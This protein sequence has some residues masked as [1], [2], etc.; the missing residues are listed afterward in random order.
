MEHITVKKNRLMTM[1]LTILFSTV[2][3][4]CAL[5]AGL[6]FRATAEED[7]GAAAAYK[8]ELTDVSVSFNDGW[9]FTNNTPD[10]ELYKMVSVAVTYKDV[11]SNEVLPARV[12]EISVSGTAATGESVSFTRDTTTRK[13]TATVTP[14]GEDYDPSPMSGTSAAYTLSNVSQ[15]VINGITATYESDGTE[16]TTTT[17]LS[18]AA[19]KRNITVYE[20]Y[21]DGSIN[22][23]GKVSSF[24]L[25]G[26][27]FPAAFTDGMTDGSTYDKEITVV[28][29]SGSA[30]V[31]ITGI[32]FVTPGQILGI[33]G[34]LQTQV[35]RSKRLNMD[36]L[37]IVVVY[38]SPTFNMITV[39]ASSF[40]SDH[41]EYKY[42]DASDNEV[43]DASGNPM[44]STA[45]KNV[46]LTFNYPGMSPV[47]AIFA[48]IEVSR[49]SI[50]TPIFPDG[51]NA[52]K[53]TLSWNNGA[54]I[55]ITSWDFDA[56][57]TDTGDAPNPV[58]TV[59]KVDV[60][61]GETPVSA[62]DAPVDDSVDGQR[63]VEFPSAGYLY[64]VKVTLPASGDFMWGSPFNGNKSDD[65]LT[66][67]FDAQVDKG[68]PEVVL[69][70]IA[71]TVYG[72]PN[73]SGTLT[74]TIE[75][76]DMGKTWSEV[77][78]PDYN[79][80]I[81][82]DGA[83]N[84]RLEYYT[85]S[86][87]TTP[88]PAADLRTDGRPKKGG[89]YYAVAVTYENSG[90]ESATSDPLEFAVK[91][92]EVN[93]TVADKTF[94]RTDWTIDDLLS[95]GNTFPYGETA[96]SI[97]TIKEG[98]VA[99]DSTKKF[100]NAGNYTVT[101]SVNQTANYKLSGASS[102]SFAIKTN[103][104]STFDFSVNG[105]TYGTSGANPGI[106][107]TA[108]SNPYYP[109]NTGTLDTDYTVKYYKYDNTQPN[110]KGAEITISSAS[111]F[112][113]LEVGGYVVE[114]TAV[115]DAAYSTETAALTA[116]TTVDYTLPVVCKEFW[117]TASPI[118]APQLSAPWDLT[119][120]NGGLLYT[121]DDTQSGQ[122]YTFT[123]W[124]GDA[125]NTAAD[126]TAILTVAIS[127]T[128]FVSGTANTVT[129]GT[130]GTFTVDY[131]GNYE[132]T[133][134]LNGN[135][136]WSDKDTV[137]NDVWKPTDKSY[138]YYGYV[139]RQQLAILSNSKIS[140]AKNVYDSTVQEKTIGDWNTN[141]LKITSVTVAGVE[142][143]HTPVSG[144]ITTPSD[145][146]NKFSVKNAGKYTVKVDI[147]DQDNYEWAGATTDAE[148]LRTLLLEYTLNRAPMKVTWGTSNL[149]GTFDKTD[150]TAYPRFEFDGSKSEQST[151]VATV[152]VYSGDVVTVGGY[153][154]YNDTDA[155]GS[156][157]TD[158]TAIGFYRIV[159]S[160]IG[161][162]AAPNY[163]LPNSSEEITRIATVFQI[164]AKTFARPELDATVGSALII[165][166][167][168]EVVYKGNGYR[169]SDFIQ[170]FNKYT[171]NGVL[172]LEIECSDVSG[173]NPLLKNVLWDSDN[174]IISYTI[175]VKPVD[176]YAWD[177]GD[178]TETLS[179]TIKITQKTV[180]ISWGT[181]GYETT[182]GE[183]TSPT[184]TV[185][186]KESGD[187]VN[188]TLGYKQGNTPV[189]DITAADAGV[190]TVYAAELDN[191]N[192][193]ID[194][195]QSDWSIPFTVKK[196]ALAKPTLNAGQ[197]KNIE[198]G[199]TT[200]TALYSNSAT[201]K[202]AW[203]NGTLFTAAVTAKLDKAWFTET[204]DDNDAVLV[205]DTTDA[206][207][208]GF[209]TA[210]GTLKYYA[211]GIYTVTF[212]LVDSANYCWAGDGKE[213]AFTDSA[214]Y[215]CAW[216][217]NKELTV[218]RK[219]IDAPAL[220]EQR[221]MEA[222]KEYD[223]LSAI[224][225]GTTDG[226]DYTVKYGARDSS[227]AFG[228]PQ[229]AQADN[230]ERGQ[231]Y[232]VLTATDKYNY[233]WAVN[234]D[235][236]KGG[237]S[238][239]SFITPQIDG[240]VYK[241]EY[242]KADGAK[243]YLLYA[244]TATQLDVVLVV[245]NY[246]YGDNGYAIGDSVIAQSDKAVRDY[247]NANGD[248]KVFDYQNHS[249]HVGAG[250]DQDTGDNKSLPEHYDP[251]YKFYKIIGGSRVEVAETDLVEG[252]PWEAGEYEAEIVID[253]ENSLAYQQWTDTRK[254][255]V[256]KRTVTLEWTFGDE[257]KQDGGVFTTTYNGEEQKPEYTVTNIPKKQ[258]GDTPTAPQLT[259]SAVSINGKVAFT[260]AATYSVNS[261]SFADSSSVNNNYALGTYT[262]GF[263]I[264]P[265]QITL[266]AMPQSHTYGDSLIFAAS[267]CL[268]SDTKNQFYTRDGS[269][270]AMRV[271]NATGTTL[272]DTRD[273]TYG[274]EFYLVPVLN[275]ANTK[276][277]NYQVTATTKAALTV[278]KR[279]IT[280]TVTNTPS[281]VYSEDIAEITYTVALNDGDGTAVVDSES[282][283]FTIAARDGSDAVITSLT[284]VG[285]YYIILTLSGVRGNNYDVT[286]GTSQA[287]AGKTTIKHESYKYTITP[288]QIEEDN[289]SIVAN[290]LTYNGGEQQFLAN[291]YAVVIGNPNLEGN[292]PVWSYVETDSDYTTDGKT[293]TAF[294]QS[295]TVKDAGT[296]YFVIKV[297]AANHTELTKNIE[298][299]VD[300]AVL[301][302]RFDLTIMF[303]EENPAT[304]QYLFGLD[305][306]RTKNIGWT[307]VGF[308][309]DDYDLFYSAA[310][311]YAL[312]G[313]AKY[314]VADYDKT[315]LTTSYDITFIATE[316]GNPTLTCGNYTFVGETGALTV[317]KVELTVTINDN[318]VTYNEQNVGNIPSVD[319]PLIG[320]TV[321]LPQSTYNAAANYVMSEGSFAEIFTVSTTAHDGKIATSTTGNVGSYAIY[322]TPKS[323]LTDKYDITFVGGW[324]ELLVATENGTCGK[325]TI[326]PATLTVKDSIADY[327]G[328]YDEKWHG[329]VVDGANTVQLDGTPTDGVVLATA[330]DGTAV[331]VEYRVSDDILP[332]LNKSEFDKL[333]LSDT[334]PKYRDVGT[335][336]VY[337]GLFNPNYVTVLAYRTVD[338]TKGNNGLSIAFNF[339]NNTVVPQGQTA[340]TA[341][342]YG[343]KCTDGFDPDDANIVIE[344]E[345]KFI[346]TGAAANAVGKI[347]FRLLYNENSIWIKT[348]DAD[349]ADT[350]TNM[351]AELFEGDG[352][353]AGNYILSVSM[354]NTTNYNG[355]TAAYVFN[356]AKR[357][358]TVKAATPDDITYGSE[359]PAFTDASVGLV[360]NS[361]KAGATADS[362]EK[363]LSTAPNY[364]T[365]Y[366]QGDNADAS[367]R[368]YV[369]GKAN[370]ATDASS[371]TNY[372][373][374]YQDVQLT[375]VPRVITVNIADKENTYNLR[376][377][378]NT[379]ETIQTLTF[380]VTDGSIYSAE[381]VAGVPEGGV[382][383]NANQSVLTLYTQAIVG[384]N[385]NNVKIEGGKV[386]GYTIYAVFRDGT[387]ATNYQ[388]NFAGCSL[389]E[390]ENSAIGGD[391]SAN[392]AGSYTI[393]KAIF[394]VNQHGVYH[395]VDGVRIDAPS[396]VYSGAVNYYVA[397][398]DDQAE[399]PIDF[400]Y[401]KKASNGDYVS[402]AANQVVGVGEYQAIG[403]STNPNY[404]AANLTI[405]FTITKATLTLTAVATRVQYGTTLSGVVATD[406]AAGGAVATGRFNGFT[407]LSSSETLLA[408]TLADYLDDNTVGY[409]TMGYSASANVGAACTITPVCDSDNN[410][411]VTTVGAALTVIKRTVTV[412]M[413][414]WNATEDGD[415]SKHNNNAWCYY[416]GSHDATHDALVDSFNKNISSYIYIADGNAVFGDSGD[417]RTA[418]GISVNLPDG[419]NVGK[420]AFTYTARNNTNYS[421][422][423]AN[424]DAPMFCVQKA[425]LTLYAHPM[426][427]EYAYTYGETIETLVDRA[428]YN[429]GNLTYFVDGMQ[430]GE[431]FVNLLDER[432]IAFTIVDNDGNAYA[433][434]ESG[435]GTYTVSLVVREGEN[436]YAPTAATFDNYE[437]INVVD[438][439]LTLNK[440]KIS[441]TTENQVFGF[442]GTNYN[443]GLYGKNHNAVITFVDVFGNDNNVDA[444]AY[445]P[446]FTLTYNTTTI[447]SYQTAGAAPTVV[448]DYKVT[449][450]LGAN[451][452]Y[453]FGD[454]TDSR[455][456]DFSVTKLVLSESNLGWDTVSYSLD[457]LDDE[458]FTNY[459]ERYVNDYFRVVRFVYRSATG[460]GTQI[461]EGDRD[462][463][464]T[465]YFDNQKMYITFGRN[466]GTY[467]LSF[468]LKDSATGN[469]ALSSAIVGEAT[470]S[471][472]V[473][474]DAV[475]MTVEIADFTY[476]D[477]P[478][479]VTVLINGSEA[480]V[481]L[482]LTYAPVTSAN[483]ADFA[484][485]SK[486]GL[487]LEKIDGLEYG[488]LSNATN[489]NAGYYVLSA[490]YELNEVITR[491]YY[492]FHVAKRVITAPQESIAQTIFNGSAQNVA[493]DY[494][495][496]YMRPELTT[497]GGSMTAANGKATFTATAVGTYAIRF[498]L[499]DPANNVWDRD[500][501][502]GE[503][504]DDSIGALTLTWNIIKDESDN[505]AEDDP[506]VEIPQNIDS[507]TYGGAFNP[508]LITVKNG[509]NGRMT[510]YRMLKTDDNTPAADPSAEGWT[511]Y[512]TGARGLDAGNYWLLVVVTDLTG[513]NFAPKAAVG[514]F[515]IVPKTITAAISGTMVYGTALADTQF[516]NIEITGLLA[517]DR[518]TIGTYSY[519]YAV[520]YA[521]LNAGGAYEI[522][523]ATDDNDVVIGIDAGS[524]YIVTAA[525]GA[526]T[527]TKR[528]VT[529]TIESKS[530]DYS[531]T[532]VLT[533]V[534]YTATGLAD[535]E[536]KS[537]LG[538]V[539]ET[540]ATDK[541][542]AGGTYWITIKSYNGTN[543]EITQ[544]RALYVINPLEIEV[545]LVRQ[546]NIKYGDSDIK[547]ATAGD[548]NIANA[549]ADEDFV[550]G[551]LQLVIR[552]TDNNGYDSFDVPTN[553]GTYTATLVGA[554]ANYRLIG[555]P[556]IDFV[557]GKKEID[558]TAF[559][560]NSATYTGNSIT[561]V[562]EVKKEGG[563]PIYARSIYAVDAGAFTDAGRHNVTVSLTDTAN[564]VWSSTT[565]AAVTLVFVI[566]KA[567]D[568]QTNKLVIAGWQYGCYDMAVNSPS[569]AVKSG[570]SI[571]YQYS[572]DGRTF[573]NIVPENGNAGTYY[574]RVT[575]AESQNYNAF[576]G[577][578]VM[579]EIAKFVVTSPSL[580]VIT[581][582]NG[583]NDVYTGG[584]LASDIVGFNPQLMQIAYNGNIQSLGDSVTVFARDAGVYT[585]SISLFNARNYCWSDGDDNNDGTLE[586]TWSVARKKVAKPTHDSSTKV[587]NGN[588]I[589]YL[590]IGFDSAIMSIENNAYSYGGTFN[591]KIALKDTKNYEW[592]TGGDA[593][594]TIK[595][596]I[597]G[598]DTVFVVII[599]ILSVLAAAGCALILV[600]F[601]L[602]RHKKR[603]TANT[604]QAIENGNAQT[605]AEQPA[606]EQAATEQSA[607]ASEGG[608]E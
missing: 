40:P 170:D 164:Y 283:V 606:T 388:I 537:V 451:S 515:R 220:G 395:D 465:Y 212:T 24:D 151:P 90:Y 359:I 162:A 280:V 240:R 590:P 555:T 231:Y 493:I 361:S 15:V 556:S 249:D 131:A 145:N 174:A 369:S 45:V 364:V 296:Y 581:D 516:D 172:R 350:V 242:T 123:K 274:G 182:Y 111:E 495:T 190:Y 39:P 161:G 71:D 205:I 583:K 41:F 471:F 66:M 110:N 67:S 281:S 284:D 65:N 558:V 312:A 229:A 586:L 589:V 473:R 401:T 330:S 261:V 351:F 140:G 267:D 269:V 512:N 597:V 506:I 158:V 444:D 100:R 580:S 544:H 34:N 461:A 279:A 397:T 273:V 178:G 210:A 320:Y 554:N 52:T 130:G 82:D 319:V 595:W 310:D 268:D 103:E 286:F 561:P 488:T 342:T 602:N 147:D 62:T 265:K 201:D 318:S 347:T 553:A 101:V 277:A 32:K 228:E 309:G 333:T 75:S 264:N 109:S 420:H 393:N 487:G 195:T 299:T 58:I 435:C 282:D 582:G 479:K 329:I 475:T 160:S 414:G 43:K 154:L 484:A 492:V 384:D 211:A 175:T 593:P 565:D 336:Y 363:A 50:H 235:D 118:V 214:D 511:V 599:T 394:N 327:T 72:T 222:E 431:K 314:S 466:V 23:N 355:F 408:D 225:T 184:P 352:L 21:N 19:L 530:S 31:L 326:N 521:N 251:V 441:A 141:A 233:A 197:F 122:P 177:S 198:F 142:T 549:D 189:A 416:L 219:V 232:V 300:K 36:G 98:G 11:D 186:N 165:G 258:A 391:G 551:D 504:S 6:G 126:G 496:A 459:I 520:T 56:L 380:T 213:S 306:L 85:D 150:S 271:Q 307:V 168:I 438:A 91:Q 474:Q 218:A 523:L 20:T 457:D 121:Y 227:G 482:T 44:L 188:I 389:M 572:T 254:F 545:E 255:T 439:T 37:N 608:A 328:V 125:N 510:L 252:L 528:A 292:A 295:P 383:N 601:L 386:V 449:V 570:E 10:S 54:S 297:T 349:A 458:T 77:S 25:D 12:L 253:F 108:K 148:K 155:F 440:R 55:D 152:S 4:G 5:F 144:G 501:A 427:G 605:V 568:E 183:V 542:A 94:A 432:N 276:S 372:T 579:F 79:A 243:V 13:V 202:A 513:R 567:N 604:M 371:F 354:A 376:G 343:Y 404:T 437:I 335:Y 412:T 28:A 527:I 573:T 569:A 423:F 337:Y 63:T 418:L 494:E 357:E 534:Q 259:F 49:I 194:D 185:S 358:L 304:E 200:A 35:A 1:L 206:S 26:N 97:L 381:L 191:L 472:S 402:I 562:V 30:P 114:L 166:N 324:N 294:T 339:Q 226:A 577:E 138:T 260:D 550:R 353:N 533:D 362:I 430:N 481:G 76:V 575:V 93:T 508:D 385:T 341:W 192:Y 96:T 548:I 480:S 563:K 499:I 445:R 375:V 425:Q 117:V 239:S 83:W 86:T 47:A 237:F 505:G 298:V 129:L 313:N 491:R 462:T 133:V 139:A 223:P 149:D 546:E 406:Q 417:D 241:I 262:L 81:N 543:Y 477:Q 266:T 73:G 377:A 187:T 400:S 208:Y 169:L 571:V 415:N 398:L 53:S 102:V 132:V 373:V 217:G 447:G 594:F 157:I 171:L 167:D 92:F 250:D 159:V 78:E 70:A 57:H 503:F 146:S 99:I 509:Y 323:E 405:G 128:Q 104:D 585:V 88:V 467:T 366:S 378:D 196:K 291:G 236:G 532:P 216:G 454:G 460:V 419:V 592:A 2:I 448:G 411:T 112:K 596:S 119:E 317:K 244:I 538:I 248:V 588:T 46:E 498:I 136:S 321:L 153:T 107:F 221:A 60:G 502:E 127:Y 428:L 3:F 263:V 421:I 559:Y 410:V 303:G 399:T 424:D 456:I 29:S 38:Y 591:A 379:T 89:T 390:T 224:F 199:M 137:G 455:T 607:N 74:A 547:G 370:G 163:Y 315:S 288:K 360:V 8:Y 106:T 331:T 120:A 143:G 116:G 433:A 293:F 179:Y 68:K 246:T 540:D 272:T 489:F 234:A 275:T 387:A 9:I 209:D 113:K 450:H 598:A 446:S 514:S 308:E 519:D 87:A 429:V 434:W 135:Y 483:A 18:S 215:T 14:A 105:W 367:Y 340:M 374:T 356:V 84:Y 603:L 531:V 497:A 524:N 464:D 382:Y 526:L 463:L 287:D 396:T 270:V 285:S 302:V 407:F 180:E 69:S 468:A 409:I 316:S 257:T 486:I 247:A 238:K 289:D 536:D 33:N 278:N 600:Q 578:P 193:K 552:F 453:V 485:N 368:V 442:D 587:V 469:L 325:Y 557:I 345:V 584:D 322:G 203:Q 443:G 245:N 535:G 576:I 560:I 59:Y 290:A 51:L 301:T 204:V 207:K 348:V 490:A 16:I 470:V 413:V 334:A 541:S 27:L 346:Y 574:V 305:S 17:Q 518:V 173:N 522:I 22:H 156:I 181:T 476:G 365:A 478:S 230:K 426:Q 344:P 7:D 452:N 403:S 115:K 422:T 61:G 124:I 338:I 80:Y 539:F 311:F 529:V 564:Y 525:R 48:D 134:T 176:N 517:G 392:N 566:N 42:T 332:V 256:Q 500:S 436:E 64:R 507:I 95:A